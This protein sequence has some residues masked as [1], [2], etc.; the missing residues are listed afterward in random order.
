LLSSKVTTAVLS[1]A[2]TT[3]LVTPGTAWRLA[4]TVRGQAAQVKIF[5]Q[6][7][8]VVFS[9][10]KVKQR[11]KKKIGKEFVVA[12]NRGE[13]RGEKLLVAT[14][15]TPNTAGL[16]LDRI[17]VVTDERGAIVVNERLETSAADIYAAGDCT[18]LP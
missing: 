3:T 11:K 1:S 13:L 9:K 14:G 17:G 4:F 16:D 18:S 12:T 6:A 2:D 15:R 7:Q 10:K 8:S 5:A